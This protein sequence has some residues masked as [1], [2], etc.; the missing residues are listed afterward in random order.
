MSD[1]VNPR[2]K[3]VLEFIVPI[4]YPE[5]PGKVSKEI[6]NTIF[7]AQAGEYKVNW[8]QI[9]QEVVR[10]LVSNLENGKASPINPYLFHLYY[11]NECLR[12]EEMKEVEVARECLEYGVGPDTPPK[13]EDTESESIDS[14]ER[15]TVYPNSRLKFTFRLLKGKS[16]IRTREWKDMSALDFDDAS[17]HRIQEELD[18]VSSRYSKMEVVIKGASKLLGDCKVGNIVKELKKLKEKDTESLEVAN[19]KLQQ[20]VNELKIALALKED[21]L[22]NFKVLRIEV[23]KEIRKIMGHSGDILN[24]AKLFNEYIN[25]DVKITMPKVITILH[26]F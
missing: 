22:T 19:R 3:R 26:D 20:E 21:E 14:E 9:I 24:K 11:T 13:E 8:G 25:K 4:L 1:C 6:G 23:L 16:P 18:Q 2:E 10:H 17:F 15:K 12:G 7:G 5:K